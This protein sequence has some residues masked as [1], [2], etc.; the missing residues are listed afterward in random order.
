MDRVHIKK[1]PLAVKLTAFYLSLIRIQKIV[2]NVLKFY[3]EH[4]LKNKIIT[5]FMNNNALTNSV[6]DLLYMYM[7]LFFGLMDYEQHRR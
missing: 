2:Y 4:T 7:I 3:I 6:K 5:N 1:K